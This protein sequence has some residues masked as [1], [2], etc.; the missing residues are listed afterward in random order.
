MQFLQLDSRRQS[1]T[2]LQG[3]MVHPADLVNVVMWLQEALLAARPSSA[4][5]Y[6]CST[7]HCIF[8][9]APAGAFKRDLYQYN[10]DS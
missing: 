9:F 4:S 6:K 5:R 7:V 10:I 1:F 8:L 2:A 3:P